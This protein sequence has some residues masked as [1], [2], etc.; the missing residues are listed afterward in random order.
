MLQYIIN[1]IDEL[2]IEGARVFRDFRKAFG[3]GVMPFQYA[4]MKS[5]GLK[6]FLFKWLQTIKYLYKLMFTMD[7]TP[8]SLIVLK[9]QVRRVL[10]LRPYVF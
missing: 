3:N 4:A 1:D 5:V 6:S 8:D 9:A 7:E 2:D 10:Y